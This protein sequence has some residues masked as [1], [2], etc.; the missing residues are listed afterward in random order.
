MDIN[1]R[2][3]DLCEDSPSSSACSTGSTILV[4]TAPDKAEEIVVEDKNVKSVFH[5]NH[6]REISILKEREESLS[7]ET[8]EQG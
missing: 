3:H 2:Q 6:T 1:H 8:P 7:N 5:I 4:N